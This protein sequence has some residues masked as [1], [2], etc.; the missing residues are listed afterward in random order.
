MATLAELQADLETL[1]SARRSGTR[2]V[3]FASGTSTRSVEYGSDRELA[4]AI[5]A[6]EAEIAAL[7]GAPKVHNV[8]LRS[9]PYRGW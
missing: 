7:Q 4:T 5:A 9:P 2:R 3:S 6:V 8:V 1:K